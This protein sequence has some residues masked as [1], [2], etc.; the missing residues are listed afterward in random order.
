MEDWNRTLDGAPIRIGIGI[1]YGP[2]ILGDIGSERRLEYAVLGDVVNVASR[3]E[4]L[5]RE[6]DSPV[7]ASAELV[8]AARAQDGVAADVLLQGYCAGAPRALKGRS[9]PIG[10]WEGGPA[11]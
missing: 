3:L 9:E 7:M 5:S 11:G 2:C 8:D 6:S 4:S 1:H 10:V